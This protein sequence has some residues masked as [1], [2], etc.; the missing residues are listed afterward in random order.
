MD[1][2]EKLGLVAGDGVEMVEL[3]SKGSKKEVI[4]M[5]DSVGEVWRQVEKRKKGCSRSGCWG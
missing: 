1:T 2:R 5:Q 4:F 3:K